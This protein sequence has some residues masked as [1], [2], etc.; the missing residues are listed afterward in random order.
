MSVIRTCSFYFRY[1]I[2][3]HSLYSSKIWKRKAASMIVTCKCPGQLRKKLFAIVSAEGKT[4]ND[5]TS[6]LKVNVAA[7]EQEFSNKLDKWIASVRC[8]P[9]SCAK[10]DISWTSS[11]VPPPPVDF[12]DKWKALTSLSGVAIVF[13]KT[14]VEVQKLVPKKSAPK[15]N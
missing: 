2:A 11:A 3:Y 1:R 10:S 4:A 7:K 14:A 13:C 5:A 12:G 15:K 6:A 9:K 8:V